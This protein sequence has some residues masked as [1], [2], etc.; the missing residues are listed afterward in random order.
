MLFPVLCFTCGK[1]IGARYEMYKRLRDKYRAASG[2]TSECLI[3]S[4]TTGD[5][6]RRLLTEEGMTAE[7]RAMR[8]CRIR[9]M[10]CRRHML[11]DIDLIEIS[12]RGAR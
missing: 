3:S 8:D 4:T 1:G 12:R 9:R 10:C 7:A 11:S 2:A 5:E 6:I